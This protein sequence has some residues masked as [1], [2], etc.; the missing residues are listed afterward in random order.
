MHIPYSTISVIT[1]ASISVIHTMKIV[2]K[3]FWEQML[4]V[5]QIKLQEIDE[6]L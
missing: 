6:N 3:I 1:D 2:L 5:Y 4:A